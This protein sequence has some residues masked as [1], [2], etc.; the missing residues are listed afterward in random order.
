M[1]KSKGMLKQQQAIIKQKNN[2]QGIKLYQQQF[3][4]CEYEGRSRQFFYDGY[5]GLDNI[6]RSSP[7]IIISVQMMLWL[8]G[9]L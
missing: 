5:N 4:L 1:A 2:E 3:V 9:N 6:G 8:S 7:D